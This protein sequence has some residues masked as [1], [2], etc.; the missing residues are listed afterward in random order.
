MAWQ[1]GQQQQRRG[2]RAAV[3]LAAQRED[4]MDGGAEH[5]Q[6]GGCAPLAG[7][8]FL[9]RH[10]ALV[11]L[12]GMLHP[13]HHQL[14]HRDLQLAASTRTW[15][16]WPLQPPRPLLPLPLLQVV[17]VGTE[18]APWSKVGGLGDVMSALPA[19]LAARWAPPEALPPPPDSTHRPGAG[20]P[21]RR[22]PEVAPPP[23]STHPPPP[24]PPQG[25]PGD[26]GRA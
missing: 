8:R 6:A 12:G 24:G 26:D 19:A 25:P 5:L 1:L 21:Y 18:V 20:R 2:S 16:T 9:T 10:L 4:H 23:L 7:H 11:L 14:A 3:S 17:F 22:S 15:P 13:M